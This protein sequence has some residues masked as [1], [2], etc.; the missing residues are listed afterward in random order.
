MKI[1]NFLY[2]EQHAMSY[3][4]N[5]IFK[6]H[7]KLYFIISV[8][9]LNN[10]YKFICRELPIKNN[11]SVEID[12]HPDIDWNPCNIGFITTH[13]Y[14]TNIVYRTLLFTRPPTRLWKLGLPFNS[15]TVSDLSTVTY[16]VTRSNF[17]YD[18][19]A[20]NCLN[21]KFFELDK[22]KALLDRQNNIFALN[23]HLIINNNYTIFY[24]LDPTKK[25]G[26]LIDDTI[27]LQS[28]FKYLK[29]KLLNMGLSCKVI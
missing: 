4:N 6:L 10:K 12:M 28:D 18:E 7:N 14:D 26:S 5:T 22:I 23:Q 13:V 15:L 17:L 20:V 3:C 16:E 29:P 2:N 8:I 19:V 9:E 1:S 25:I 11:I 24:Y 27:V 21:N